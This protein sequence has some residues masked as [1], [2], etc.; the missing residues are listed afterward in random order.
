MDKSCGDV[1][2]FGHERRC[3][4]AVVE[5]E[6]SGTRRFTDRARYGEG[7][8][9]ALPSDQRETLVE[10]PRPPPGVPVDETR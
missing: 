7:C 4:G 8:S 3:V 6:Q 5:A 9:S 1:R 10:G 2:V